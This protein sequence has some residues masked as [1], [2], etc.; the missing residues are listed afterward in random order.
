MRTET[1]A[2]QTVISLL[3]EKTVVQ[4]DDILQAFGCASRR[5]VCRKLLAVGCRSSYSHCG[6]FYT[7]DELA[8]YDEHGLW[9]YRGIRFSRAGTLLATAAGLVE[10]APAGRFADEL[11]QIV[12]LEVQ[13]ALGKLVRTRR[14][15]RDKLAGQFLYA[16]PCRNGARSSCGP[17]G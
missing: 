1:F 8:A 14:L 3:R 11:G 10:Q 7:L 13:N 17:A 16:R 2:S 5:T 12:Q 9:S 4:L 15:T 6:R